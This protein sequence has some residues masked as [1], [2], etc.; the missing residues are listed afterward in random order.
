MGPGPVTGGADG[1][2]SAAWRNLQQLM[3]V[4]PR[5]RNTG[6]RTILFGFLGYI[7]KWVAPPAPALTHA[8]EG[9]DVLILEQFAA[10]QG[11]AAQGAR[12]KWYRQTSLE[13]SLHD[14]ANSPSAFS[15]SPFRS[16]SDTPPAFPLTRDPSP[17]LHW[18]QREFRV[19]GVANRGWAC[20]P[21]FTINP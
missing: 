9:C 10:A 3:Q 5:D 11:V 18:H 13:G 8:L 12:F 7:L 15:A 21:P 19:R 14:S 6:T 20:A 1:T 2:I 4:V 17:H 16:R